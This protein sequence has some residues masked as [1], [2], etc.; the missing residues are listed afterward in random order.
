MFNI[1]R[2]SLQQDPLTVAIHIREVSFLWAKKERDIYRQAIVDF[3]TDD[4]QDIKILIDALGK[5]RLK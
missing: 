4:Q 1:H 2:G 3:L 5:K